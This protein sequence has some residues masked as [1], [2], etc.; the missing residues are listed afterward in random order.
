MKKWHALLEYFQFPLKLLFFATV[1]LG[2]G[3]VII[4]PNIDPLLWHIDNDI[5][6]ILAEMLRFIGGF[7]IYLFPL[8]VFFKILS[9]RY[10]DSVP[11]FVGLFGYIIMN[12]TMMFFIKGDLP[13]YYYENTLGIQAVFESSSV[14]GDIVRYPYATGFISLILTYF[15]V[16]KFYDRSRLHSMQGIL[17]FLDHD[18]WVMLSTFLICAITGILLAFVWPYVIDFMISIFAYIGQDITDPVNLF[19]Y[20]V[21]ERIMAV[22]NLVNIPRNIFWLGDLGGSFM[23]TSGLKHVGDVSIWTYQIANNL[24]LSAGRFITPYY[25]IN[26]F[27]IPSFLLGF[28]SLVTAKKERGRYTLFF[29][30]AVFVSIVCGNALPMEIMMLI[31]APLLYVVYILFVGG[32]FAIFQMMDVSIGYN[33]SSSLMIANPGSLLDLAPLIRN[34]QMSQD[35]LAMLGVGFIYFILFFFITRAYFKKYAIGFLNFT[36][37]KKIAK[38]IIEALGGIHNILEVESTPD[39]LTVVLEDRLNIDTEL[40][41]KEGAYLILEAKNGLLIR[42]GNISTIVAVEIKN[43][44][45]HKEKDVEIVL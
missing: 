17:S 34:P 36:S 45:K 28:L 29:I 41:K 37:R 22:F 19:F 40:L 11:V 32:L 9:R 39:K 16:K 23:E 44:I 26:I 43:N 7:I 20:G 6:I 25:V 31:L 8:F 24:D 14:L 27:L 42:L 10:E 15:I 33:F 18:S 21:V 1:L 3:S 5:V 2:I 13:T 12:I 30:I 4:N 35:I 38:R